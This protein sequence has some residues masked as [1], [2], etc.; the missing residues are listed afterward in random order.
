MRWTQ[1]RT[2]LQFLHFTFQGFMQNEGIENAKSLTYT[3]LF[4]VVPLITLVFAILSAFPSFQVFGSQIQNMIFERLLPS[5]TSELAEYLTNFSNQARNLTWIGAVMLLVTSYLMLRNIERSFN[6]I[7]GVGQLR[8]GLSSFL[9]YWSVLSLGPLMLGV[10]FAISSYVASLTLFDQVVNITDFFGADAVLLELFPLVLTTGAF[11][12]LYAAVPNCGVQLRHAF[13]GAVVVALSFMVVKWVFTSFIAGASY[14]LVYGT[15][16]AIP[17]F[18]MWIYVCWVVILMGANLV[19]SIPLFAMNAM[20]E[21][22]HPSLVLL[23]LMHKLWERQQN[24][25]ILRVQ[26]LMDEKWPF[27]TIAVGRLLA[28]LLQ[29]KIIRSLNHDEY[30]LVRDLESITLWEVLSATPWAQPNEADLAATVPPVL[31]R[32]LPDSDVLKESFLR[33]ADVSRREFCT[34]FS[35]YFRNPDAWTRQTAQGSGRMKL[36]VP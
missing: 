32:H 29:L 36:A 17:I 2:L 9:L 19:R 7:W 23:A 6:L 28:L 12:L 8:Q 24:G 30:I 20:T 34:S 35:A 33:V 1:T 25:E 22:A 16:A 14:E 27:R 5:S 10:G 21:T 18:L 11:T 3:S 13:A 15:F 26:E 31:A 4:A